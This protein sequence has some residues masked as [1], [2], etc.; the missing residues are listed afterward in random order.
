MQ[1]FGVAVL[2]YTMVTNH[3]FLIMKSLKRKFDQQRKCNALQSSY[4][5]F[6]ETV[7]G[8]GFHKRTI[9]RGFENLVDKDDYCP[10]EKESIIRHLYMLT[11]APRRT[12]G[13]TKSPYG[14]EFVIGVHQSTTNHGNTARSN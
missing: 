5:C 6:A 9:A 12:S 4:L 7:K 3:S 11:N 1:V 2:F 14:G 13:D 10:A 8:C